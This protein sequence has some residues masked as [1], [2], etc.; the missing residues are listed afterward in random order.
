MPFASTAARCFIVVYAWPT[1]MAHL[2]G[3]TRFHAVTC[4]AHN[5]TDFRA[6]AACAGLPPLALRSQLAAAGLRDRGSLEQQLDE[7]R[8]AGRVRLFRLPTGV[9]A[10]WAPGVCICVS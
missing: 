9:C 7:Q 6:H 1:F 4:V 2:H 10:P 5:R 3:P 8:Q